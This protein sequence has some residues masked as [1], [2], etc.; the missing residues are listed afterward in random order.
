MKSMVLGSK[1]C[2]VA[3]I[4]E[5]LKLVGQGLKSASPFSLLQTKTFATV[6]AGPSMCEENKGG[7]YEYSLTYIF[8]NNFFRRSLIA[9][10]A[11]PTLKGADVTHT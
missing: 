9:K 5:T 11:A 7:T 4:A 3:K 8:N 10:M 2:Q 6:K 1:A